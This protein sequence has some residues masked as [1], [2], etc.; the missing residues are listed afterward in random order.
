MWSNWDREANGQES[1]ILAA[2]KAGKLE[3]WTRTHDL[4]END[5]TVALCLISEVQ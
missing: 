4:V 3:R 2:S 1:Y 5:D